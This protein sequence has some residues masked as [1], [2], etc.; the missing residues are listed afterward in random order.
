MKYCT[1]CG[2]QL[3]DDAIFCRICGSKQEAV[4]PEDIKA[5]PQ[6]FP[7][8]SEGE[9]VEIDSAKDG[10]EASKKKGSR[11]VRTVDGKDPYVSKNVVLCTDGKYRWVYEMSL[12]KDFSVFW[13]VLK[14]FVGIIIAFGVIAFIIELFGDHNYRFVFEA[15]GIMLAIFTVL[16][17]LGYLLYAAVMGGKFCVLYTMDDKGILMEQQA[18]Q[19]KK[20]EIIADLLVLAGALSGRVTT[21]G[22]GLSSARRTSMYSTFKGTKKLTAAA[23][24][25]LIK[26]DAP[27][28]HNR[29]WCEDD[30]DYNFVWN[31][32]KSRCEGAKII[33]KF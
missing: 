9:I 7:V 12:L 3:P 23:K 11:K 25:D 5:G 20:A 1:K 17:V 21:V 13:M 18:K 26:M 24:K 16:S 27:L 33:E 28:D 30:E 31:Y 29:I 22:M 8:G 4:S 14:I 32:I 10:V 6:A 2:A 19:A 15:V